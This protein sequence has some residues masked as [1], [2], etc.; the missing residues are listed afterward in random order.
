M[1]PADNIEKLIK[2]INYKTS[3]ETHQRIFSNVT[4]SLDKQEKLKSGVAKPDIWRTIMKSKITKLAATAVIILVILGGVTFWPDGS[5]GSGKWWLGPTAAWSQEIL[6]ELN[7]IKGISCHEQIEIVLAD[8]SKLNFNTSDM[9]YISKDSY[10]RDIYDGDFLKEIQWYIPD[11]NSTLS[12]SINF[13]TKSYFIQR[14]EG[15]FGNR[16]PIERMRFYV[17]LL[18]KADSLLDEEII[19]GRTCVG[20]EISTNKYGSN[21]EG[22][23]DCI[24]FDVETKLPVRIEQHGR[25]VTDQPDKTCTIIQEQFDYNPE[26]PTDTFIPWIPEGFTYGHPDDVRATMEQE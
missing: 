13:D 15:S 4:Q 5:S 8:G 24:W 10:R 20:F 25:P 16:D 23:F 18:D 1:R 22:W 2:K 19:E 7:T 11:G 17:G 21:P 9:L 26:F 3:A 6:N 12:Q 14:G